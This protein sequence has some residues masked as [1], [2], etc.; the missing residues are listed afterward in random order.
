MQQQLT[1]IAGARSGLV[2]DISA[3]LAEADI[4]IH[5]IEAFEVAAQACI[6]L[7]VDE[8]D[9]AMDV[10]NQ[11]G[12][13]VVTEA[14]L[15]LQIP[16]RPGALAKISRQLKDAQVE[17][18]AITMVHQGEEENIV[19]LACEDPDKARELLGSWLMQ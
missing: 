3:A 15:L 16:D 5:A 17:I 18:R 12:L 9:R 1:V 11:Q 7:V 8:L 14:V 4:N 10:L 13:T 6:R 19:A 2:A